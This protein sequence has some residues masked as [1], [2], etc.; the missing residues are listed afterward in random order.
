MKKILFCSIG[1]VLVFL[2][3]PSSVFSLTKNFWNDTLPNNIVINQLQGLGICHWESPTVL[4]N[5]SCSWGYDA[6]EA[7]FW[8]TIEPNENE[9]HWETLDELV[10][11]ARARGKKVWLQIYNDSVVPD[12]AKQKVIAGKKMEF[13]GSYDC[14]TADGKLPVPWNEVYLTLWRKVIHEMAKRYDNNPTVEAIIMMAGGGYGEMAVSSSYGPTK[15]FAK[16]AGCCTQCDSCES[17]VSCYNCVDNKWSQSVTN[18]IDLYLEEEHHWGNEG[19]LPSG[20][21]THGFLHKPVV[22]QL[23]AG[24]YGHTTLVIKPVLKYA[25]PKYGMRVILKTNGWNPTDCDHGHSG[26][27]NDFIVGNCTADNP[28]C[29]KTKFCLEPAAIYSDPNQ[30]QTML[31]CYSYASVDCL[32]NDY[33]KNA[34]L[35]SKITSLARSLGAKVALKE[36]TFPEQVFSGQNYSFSL[37]LK[38]LGNIPPFRPKRERVGS[39]LKDIASSYQLSFQLVKDG[40]IAFQTEIIPS[41]SSDKWTKNQ[42]ISLTAQFII[43][44]LIS[45]NYELR[46]ALFDP[47]ANQMTRQEYFRFLNKDILDDQGRAKIGTINVVSCEGCSCQNFGDLDCNTQIN[48][49]DLTTL[50]DNWSPVGGGGEAGALGL[51]DGDLNQDHKIDEVDLTIILS[52]WKP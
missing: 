50:I 9:F 14:S 25:I 4:D 15:C 51:D 28:N 18:I 41:P 31:N 35:G 24:P 30:F 6:T 37:I 40:Q 52:S 26:V 44:P 49:T 1:L 20:T 7:V 29:D 47:E 22:L 32:Q 3:N 16:A 39:T 5:P 2:T 19:I 38:N 27:S 12:W 36:A 11:R 23:G 45:G 10:E 13:L 8:K 46:I 48:G 17:N 34:N 42:E 21:I 43:P 33:W